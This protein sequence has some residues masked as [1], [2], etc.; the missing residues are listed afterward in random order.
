[1]EV[2]GK[3]AGQGELGRSDTLRKESLEIL[4]HIYLSLD[5]K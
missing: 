5:S 1:V 2:I 3:R 4:D